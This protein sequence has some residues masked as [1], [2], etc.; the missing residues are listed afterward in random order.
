MEQQPASARTRSLLAGVVCL[1]WIIG[2]ICA[3]GLSELFDLDREIE[4]SSRSVACAKRIE[5]FDFSKKHRK[6]YG[7]LRYSTIRRDFHSS[8]IVSSVALHTSKRN[9]A[10]LLRLIDR[11][12]TSFY[13]ISNV[14]VVTI[15]GSILIVFKLV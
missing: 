9:F 5:Q 12:K 2:G 13:Y 6:N 10:P 8:L 11:L 1:V 3:T 14:L 7:L 15:L 4:F